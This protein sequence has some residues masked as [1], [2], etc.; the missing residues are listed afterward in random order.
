MLHDKSRKIFGGDRTQTP[1]TLLS[2]IWAPNVKTGL[3]PLL[4]IIALQV[5][6]H[7]LTAVVLFTL[8]NVFNISFY[9]VAF[10]ITF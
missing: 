5:N 10:A 2:Q 6:T 1:P 9:G 7:P 8:Y 3:M 4:V